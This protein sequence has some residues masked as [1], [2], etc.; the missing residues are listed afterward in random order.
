MAAMTDVATELEP[1][2]PHA[3][4][5][6]VEV[7]VNPASGG[8]NPGAAGELEAILARYDIEARVVEAKP[9]ELEAALKS[10]VD[11]KPD[12][13]VTLAGDGTIRAAGE[14]CGPDGPLLIAL[15]GGTMNMLPK[16][17][18]NTTDW[19]KALAEALSDGKVR[20]VGGG[21]VGD[22]TFYCAAIFGHPALWGEA[23]EAI[24]EGKFGQAWRRARKA[25]RR[26]FSGR[27]RFYLDDGRTEKAE[28]VA[29]LTPLISRVMDPDETALEAASMDP[30]SSL[31][32][33]RMAFNFL[34]RDWR[35]DPAV[36]TRPARKAVL[37]ARRAL[38]AILDGET[39]H[40]GRRAE[41]SFIPKAFRA[42]APELPVPESV[43]T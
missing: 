41:V 4:V 27:L 36:N 29:F 11:A 15:P 42:L 7:V 23:R 30:Q 9:G 43:A 22:H 28:A 25:L 20:N 16:A 19:K 3:R 5:R 31:D 32:A 17:L 12:V 38:P 34:A 37:S 24:R 1:L 14:L 10:A 35:D 40:L 6:R 8:V 18:Y 26:A 21:A 13:L 33:F 39:V 2:T